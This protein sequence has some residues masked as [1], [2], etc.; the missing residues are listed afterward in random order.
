MLREVLSRSPSVS[1]GES[2]V[3]ALGV[4]LTML[5]KIDGMRRHASKR[6]RNVERIQMPADRENR[7]NDSTEEEDWEQKTGNVSE[8]DEE[9]SHRKK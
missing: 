4:Y 7:G 8:S 9:D 1:K 6:G 5:D 2:L 3:D